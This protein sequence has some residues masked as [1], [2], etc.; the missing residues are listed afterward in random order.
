MD[1]SAMNSPLQE[2]KYQELFLKTRERLHKAH[3]LYTTHPSVE[4]SYAVIKEELDE[5]WDEIKIKEGIRN[6]QRI[7]DEALDIA[8][9]ALRLIHD[10]H[11]KDNT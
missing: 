8:A 1:T 7:I 11:L 10:L 4:H 5:L 3:T 9:T 6:E 2:G